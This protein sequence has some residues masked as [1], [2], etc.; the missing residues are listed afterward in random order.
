MTEAAVLGVVAADNVGRLT[1]LLTAVCA[2]Y[3]WSAPDRLRYHV[4]AEVVA[5][6]E[7]TKMELYRRVVVP[8]EERARK[9][10]GDVEAIAEL[11]QQE[12]LTDA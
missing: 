12:G 11:L 8:Y 9:E 6:L 3:L 7:C 4:I 10:N 1:Y 5:A 2:E